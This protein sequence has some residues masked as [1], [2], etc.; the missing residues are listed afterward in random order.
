MILALS[1]LGILTAPAQPRAEPTADP[2]RL[3]LPAVQD[4]YLFTGQM[5]VRMEGWDEEPALIQ[6]DS[7]AG[8]GAKVV[9]IHP[10]TLQGMAYF[11]DGKELRQYSPDLNTVRIRR[12]FQSF[13]PDPGFLLKLVAKNYAV[14]AIGETT[15]IGRKATIVTASANS[16][17]LGIRRFLIDKALPIVLEDRY[18]AEGATIYRIRTIQVR[19]TAASD[20]DL[21]LGNPPNAG[22]AR[23][24][25]PKDISDM[26]YAAGVLKFTPRIPDKIPFG[27]TVFARQLVGKE[28]QPFLAVRVTDGLATAHIYEWKYGRG[29][30]KTMAEIPAMVIDERADLAYAILGDLPPK[31]ADTVL[32]A[33]ANALK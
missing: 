13:W 17:E 19:P 22:T 21:E 31:A 16:Q 1:W 6:I 15:H 14:K 5:T 23:S 20:I 7:V 27:F 28:E 2:L 32:K 26:K 24:W 18:S 4:D 30:F 33:F 3:L 11:D 9:W 10:S 25:G 8:K 12:S 29:S